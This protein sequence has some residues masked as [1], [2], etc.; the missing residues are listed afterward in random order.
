MQTTVQEDAGLHAEFNEVFILECIMEPIQCGDELILKAYDE[1]VVK[2]EYLGEI[3]P[4]PYQEL[5]RKT[6]PINH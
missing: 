6:T 2:N 3:L 4:L 1:D 5:V